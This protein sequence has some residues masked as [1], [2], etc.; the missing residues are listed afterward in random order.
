MFWPDASVPAS[1][2][3]IMMRGER[4]FGLGNKAGN[5]RERGSWPVGPGLGLV[6][7]GKRFEA[8][9]AVWV[10]IDRVEG[11]GDSEGSGAQH[12]LG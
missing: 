5:Q 6:C 10:K 4:R 1:Y 2:I 8:V 9:F 11:H 7:V 12:F 3:F